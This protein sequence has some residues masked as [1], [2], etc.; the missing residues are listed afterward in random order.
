MRIRGRRS[1]GYFACQMD[2]VAPSNLRDQIRRNE[3]DK[4]AGIYDLG[5]LPESREMLLVACNEVIGAGGVGAFDKDVIVWIN[6][7]LKWPRA[8]DEPGAVFDKCEELP[9]KALSDSEFRA[10]QHIPVFRENGGGNVQL[11]RF[12][13]RE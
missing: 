9:L 13:C 4:L 7:D 2:D 12:G 5:P 10:R 8:G 6:R 11:C 1:R 3:A